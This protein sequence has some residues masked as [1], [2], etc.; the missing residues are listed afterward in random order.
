MDDFGIYTWQDGRMYEGFYREDKKH[1]YGIYTWSDQ[2]KYSGWWYQGKQHGLG[3]F[4]SKEGAKRKFGVWE[5]GKKIRWFSREEVIAI[6]SGQ[7]DDLR[8]IFQENPEQSNL[9]IRE[10]S[11]QFLAPAIFYQ[12]RQKL[13]TKIKELKI[14]VEVPLLVVDEQ[15]QEEDEDDEEDQHK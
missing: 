9:K 15:L 7:I 6:E 11:K 2:K 5:D 3:V 8:E 4:I 14:P 1:G 13:I 12:A 10:F